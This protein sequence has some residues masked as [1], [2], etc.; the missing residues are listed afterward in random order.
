VEDDGV[1][2]P[3]LVD[4]AQPATLGFRI[5]RALIDQIGAT[6]EVDRTRG[7]RIRF[8]LEAP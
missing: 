7:T 6:L 8:T 2:L 4:M 5:A 3:D 1:G